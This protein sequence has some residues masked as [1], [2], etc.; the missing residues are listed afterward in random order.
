MILKEDTARIIS[1]LMGL[2]ILV[3]IFLYIDAIDLNTELIITLII[4]LLGIEIK[5]ISETKELKGK[6]ET[7]EKYVNYISEFYIKEGL[8][9]TKI[10]K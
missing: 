5:S 9:D 6:V 3:N 8:M 7:I 4:T 2:W 10:K 1:F